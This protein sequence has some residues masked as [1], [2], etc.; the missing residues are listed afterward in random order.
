MNRREFFQD[1]M[2]AGV[3]LW[4][5]KSSLVRSYAA[6][7]KLDIAIIGA[8]GRG[9]DNLRAVSTENIVALCDVDEQRAADSFQRFP[10][11]PKYH[12][13]RRMLEERANSIDAVVVSTPDHTHAVAAVRAMQ[14]GKHVYCEKP[15]TY[16]VEEARVMRETAARYGVA[17]QMGNQGT[18]SEGF[19]RGVEIVQ[20]GTLGAV[21]EVHIW[22]NRPVWPQG[23]DRPAETP[24]VP[25]HLQWDLW[26]GPAPER[27]YHPAYLPFNWRGWCD[28]GT[29]ALG[30]M[31]CHTANLPFMALQLG[32]PQT[33]E[34]E[35]SGVNAETFPRWSI[36][37]QEFPAR[38][39]LPPVRL[40]W[41]DGGQKPPAELLLGQAM[42][43]SG[44][45]LIGDRGTLFSPG[46]YGGEFKL[47]PED[48]FADYEGP[49]PTLPRSP[50]HH[51]EWIRACKGGP[52]AMSHFEYAA[53]LT[54]ML[55]LGNV[56]LRLGQKIT[57]DAAEMKAVNCPE[58]D[59][60]L[61]RT[62]RQGW[63]LV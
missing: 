54:E 16:S 37:R 61:R 58:A 46:D 8:G 34:A 32:L 27:P 3:G 55:L 25:P 38:G 6:N 7:E 60:Y 29:G 22:T 36:I 2:R 24:P 53:V 30:D 45:L 42:S 48:R 17:T 35:S 59:R 51:Q 14:L 33:V 20:A 1:T 21:R 19:R 57:W 56:A 11:V 47:L 44:C 9:G 12:D 63:E 40:T 43:E 18:A 5:L 52:P 49:E 62:Y 15:L 39:D 31:G 41:Y 50:G 10:Q 28:F 23:L 26:L 4:V 13:F